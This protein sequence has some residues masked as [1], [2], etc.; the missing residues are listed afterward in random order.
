M[1]HLARRLGSRLA[2]VVIGASPAF[3]QQ[4]P[5]L[6]YPPGDAAG[7][8]AAAQKAAR[9]DGRHVLL[10]FGADWCPDCRVLGALLE[11]PAVAPVVTANFHVVRIDVGRRDKNGDLVEKYRATSGDW[12]PALVVLAPDGATIAVTDD[13]VRITRRTGKDD[14][15]TLL[16]SWAPKQRVK[17]LAAFVEHGVHVSLNLERDRSGG[18]WLSGIFAPQAESTHLYST[19]LPADGIQGLGRPTRLVL[20][21]ESSI[22]AAG[23][24][25]A[26]RAVVL[27]RIDE[28]NVSLP[29]YP[30]GSVTLRMP[31]AIADRSS[32]T[33]VVLVSYMA[34]GPR[35]CLRPVI[36]R[37]VVIDL[38]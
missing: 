10:D 28:L 27:D 15:I 20:A 29:V 37:R 35:G 25:V 3:A 31:V 36:D 6:L 21:P 1:A 30:D 24:V 17:A 23:P 14:L 33:A 34:C 26:D 5:K 11:D 9:A 8:I 16:K 12:I 4:T 19:E 32:G 38:R 13:D 18:L 22:S 7:E 2:V